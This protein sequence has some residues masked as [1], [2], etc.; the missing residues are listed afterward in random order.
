MPKFDKMFN[1]VYTIS[2]CVKDFF[3]KLT[4]MIRPGD[5]NGDGVVNIFDFIWAEKISVGLPGPAEGNA[6]ADCNGVVN[7][8]DVI[9]IEK[10]AVGLL[11][12]C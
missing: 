11:G 5:S 3:L 7:I 4:V 2:S 1:F 9:W 12:K 10:I 8:F 6:D